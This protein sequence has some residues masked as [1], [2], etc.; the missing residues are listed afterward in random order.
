MITWEPWVDLAQIPVGAYDAYLDEWASAIAQT[1]SPVFV[2][3]GH[4]MNGCIPGDDPPCWYPW[5]GDPE[6]YRAAWR[7]VHDRIEVVN[8]VE[9]AVWAWTP[10]ATQGDLFAD[11]GDYYPGDGYV[12]W[13]GASGFNA[14]RKATWDPKPPCLTFDDLFSPILYDMAARY[15]K[16]QVVAEFASAC[17][18]GC[19]KA[20][21]IAEAYHQALFH[22]RLRALVWFNVAKWEGQGAQRKWVD[23][24]IDCGGGCPDCTAA[25]ARA[26][27]HPR[28]LCVV[29][30]TYLPLA[31]WLP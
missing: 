24:R 16:P 15:P 23:W 20:L 1:Q 31:P 11:Y 14:A 13:V 4:E 8:G 2:R 19:D 18:N 9:N 25:Y 12:D 17:D 27:A 30:R 7:Y 29:C 10:N 21:W 28:Y 3:W 5:G 22:P 26:L 6:A